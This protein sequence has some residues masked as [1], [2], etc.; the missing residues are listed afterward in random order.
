MAT[1]HPANL[2]SVPLDLS[3]EMF[4]ANLSNLFLL[5]VAATL[6]MAAN[7]V[8][9]VTAVPEPVPEADSVRY[10]VGEML[11]G[12]VILPLSLTTFIHTSSS[13]IMRIQ[14]RW[15]FRDVSNTP[16]VCRNLLD[17]DNTYSSL[18]I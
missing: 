2:V 4:S 10:K 15:N 7:L 8:R 5:S 3:K 13:V 14:R 17:A 16:S 12:R 11:L 9:Y 6:L 18:L 1:R